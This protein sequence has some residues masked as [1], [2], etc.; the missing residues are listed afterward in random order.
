MS[1]PVEPRLEDVLQEALA[2][3]DQQYQD[4]FG[5]PNTW[6]QGAVGQYLIDCRL[7]R[8]RATNWG[9]AA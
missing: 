5:P 6:S 7:A 9:E 2:A 8:M 3:V 4:V 1:A